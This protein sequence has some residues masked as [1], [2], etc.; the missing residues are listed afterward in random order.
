[1]VWIVAAFAIAVQLARIWVTYSTL[2]QQFHRDIKT[3]LDKAVERYY[4]EIGTRTVSIETD[5]F[6]ELSILDSEKTINKEPLDSNKLESGE[7][8]DA[9]NSPRKKQMLVAISKDTVELKELKNMLQTEI[10][11]FELKSEVGLVHYFKGKKNSE[12]RTSSDFRPKYKIFSNTR[13][14]PL[15]HQIELNYKPNFS[16]TLIQGGVEVLVSFI[17]LFLI[18][19][20]LWKLYSIVKRQRD[21]VTLKNDFVNNISHEFKTPI[22]AAKVAIEAAQRFN[23]QNDIEKNR[24]Y[25]G[26]AGNYLDQV[27]DM[28]DRLLES[29]S[30]ESESDVF[31]KRKI[32]L[33]KLLMEIVEEFQLSQASK[34]IEF[35]SDESFLNAR[36]DIFYLKRAIVNIVDNSV[37][38]GGEEIKIKLETTKNEAILMVSDNGTSLS[39]EEI[40]RVFEQFYRVPGENLRLIKGHGIG[41]YFSKK[42]IE[43]HS[44]TIELNLKNGWTN[45]IIKLPLA[46]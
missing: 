28:I 30:F 9:I 1:M 19:F 17:F 42:V 33:V 26:V 40:P 36:A 24:K 27:S 44:G 35:L 32:D 5:S 8:N 46:I 31:I 12:F 41:L 18:I 34:K 14:L 23:P 43:A 7:T 13:A 4:F 25:L 11:F 15:N 29:A 21:L 3:A 45:F 22:S 20:A 10:D 16:Y 6:E 2:Q 37:K 39:K 38:Y